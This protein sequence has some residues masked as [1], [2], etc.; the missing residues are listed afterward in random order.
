[1]SLLGWENQRELAG[2]GQSP[3]LVLLF[4]GN[5]PPKAGVRQSQRLAA[6]RVGRAGGEGQ[7]RGGLVPFQAEVATWPDQ[8]SLVQNDLYLTCHTGQTSIRVEHKVTET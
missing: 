4:C 5:P 6:H 1:M 2:R 8:K 7:A 3:I